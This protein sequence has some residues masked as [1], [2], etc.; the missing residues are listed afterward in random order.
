MEARWL[1]YMPLESSQTHARGT[2]KHPHGYAE[3]SPAAAK[4]LTPTVLIVDA[5]AL[6]RWSLAETLR[7]AGFQVVE[8]GDGASAIRAFSSGG[9]PTDA[10]ILDPYLPDSGDLRLLTALRDFS[11]TTP[12][13]LMTAY[14]SSAL[15]A[16]A[17]GQG[18]FMVLDKPFEMSAVSPILEHALHA[19]AS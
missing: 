11:P 16:E 15:Q 6:L 9:V 13:I 1:L 8:A 7:D 19:V 18:A 17:C 12:V 4:K 3:N 5:E 10:V 14:G 2:L